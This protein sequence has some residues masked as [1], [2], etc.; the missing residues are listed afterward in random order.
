M[1]CK[2]VFTVSNVSKEVVLISEEQ[3]NLFFVVQK[4]FLIKNDAA[5]IGALGLGARKARV[6]SRRP[7]PCRR[8]FDNAAY[9]R[10]TASGCGA[11]QG[12]VKGGAEGGGSLVR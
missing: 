8:D 6:V 1:V 2:C 5:W 3:T 12:G 9:W 11:A 7:G 10:S 4:Y